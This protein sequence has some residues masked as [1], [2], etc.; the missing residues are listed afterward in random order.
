MVN[1]KLRNKSPNGFTIVAFD[2]K[3]TPATP[4]IMMENS[5]RNVDL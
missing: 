1:I 3:T 5:K 2:P 4:P